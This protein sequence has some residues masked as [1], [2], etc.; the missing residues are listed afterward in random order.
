[1][2]RNWQALVNE[3]LMLS[4]LKGKIEGENCALA[5]RF[6]ALNDCHSR[7]GKANPYVIANRFSWVPH[8]ADHDFAVP[9]IVFF[10]C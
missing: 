4:L 9:D 8:V 5:L 6:L 3:A 7:R 10:P 1:M 2:P